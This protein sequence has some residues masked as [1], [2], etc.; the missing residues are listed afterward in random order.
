MLS[1]LYFFLQLAAV[2][3]V[4]T[5]I[6]SAP[7]VKLDRATLI[8]STNGS[9]T[10][11]M[12]IPFAEPPLGNLRL[13]LPKPVSGYAGTINATLPATQ[14]LQLIPP[15]R[16]DMPAE[17]LQDM[18]AYV[19]NVLTGV[20]IPEGEDCLT[21]NVQVPAGTKPEDKLPV[22]VVS[23][24]FTIGSSAQMPGDAVVT[25][26]V[27]L[28]KPVVYVALNYRLHAFGFLGGK[29]VKEAGVGNLGLHDQ[30]EALRW[31]QKHISVFGGDPKK[32]TIWGSSSGAISSSLQMV[33]NGGNNEGLFRGA[34]MNAG[35]PIPTGDI[36]ELQQFYDQIVA[37][38]GCAN[39]TDTLD[40]L[41]KIPAANLTAAAATVPNLFDYTGLATPWPPR[42]DGV[43]LT[44][45][46][47]HLVLAG[48][49]AKIPFMSG[50]ALDEGTIFATGSFNVTTEDQ[51][52][53]YVHEF[54]FPRT[55]KA[56]LAPIFNLY[57][58]DPAQGSPVG[59]GD[60]N[61]LAPMYKR[62]AAF[63]GDVIFQAPRRFFL[64]QRSSKQPTWSFISKRGSSPGLGYAHGSDFLPALAF[65]NELTDYIIQFATHLDPNG[66]SNRTIAWPKY[67]SVSRPVLTLHDGDVPLA[68][69]TDDVRL[70]PMQGVTA[71][72]I[73]SP[74]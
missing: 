62:M 55:P 1:R 58:N 45:P 22:I 71:V 5:A 8:G 36:T 14:C 11:F 72:G 43:F 16:T 15:V 24:G 27:Q 41:R 3:S 21:V 49:V 47:Q 30:R 19:G 65:G 34:I 26:S 28:G 42:A 59:T 9:V 18:E 23:R 51:F 54:F 6:P 25:R 39:A 66:A 48:Q 33:T 63:Q 2:L 44:A 53:D 70:L 52:R 35:S 13:R 10:S 31:V 68:I 64:D 50:D 38:A 61:Q 73:V 57:P 12:G 32:V 4:T 67:D 60:A 20:P 17:M 74:L 56:L 40:C 37:H 69:E 29:E 46:P 7:T